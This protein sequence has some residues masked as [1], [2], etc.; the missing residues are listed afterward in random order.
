[1]RW[2]GQAS[3]LVVLV[4]EKVLDAEADGQAY[5]AF[6]PVAGVARDRGWFGVAL[7]ELGSLCAEAL[8]DLRVREEKQMISVRDR[9]SSLL[10]LRTHLSL[11]LAAIAGS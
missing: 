9:Q 10:V 2:D 3:F 5:D 6:L 7:V 8:V 11:D 4:E 1:M